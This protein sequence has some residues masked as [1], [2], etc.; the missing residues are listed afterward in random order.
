MVYS[1]MQTTKLI[2]ITLIVLAAVLVGLWYCF[3]YERVAYFDVRPATDQVLADRSRLS[4]MFVL[5]KDNELHYS[6][7]Q[8]FSDVN[9]F[10]ADTMRFTNI[11]AKL[12]EAGHPEQTLSYSEPDEGRYQQTYFWKIS[13]E[14]CK[15]RAYVFELTALYENNGRK[16]TLRQQFTLERQTTTRE[17]SWLF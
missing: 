2:F 17:R 10:I 1:F 11:S 4:Q 5:N 7:E 12:Y 3:K 13:F 6:F 15:A 16:D 8:N 9:R 14:Q